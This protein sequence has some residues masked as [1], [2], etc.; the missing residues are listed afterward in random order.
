[1]QTL[2]FKEGF[3]AISSASVESFFLHG[4][5]PTSPLR[6]GVGI[7]TRISFGT[8]R[9]R[10]RHKSSLQPR[11]RHRVRPQSG[12]RV[13][14]QRVRC[15]H[16]YHSTQLTA[17]KYLQP[18]SIASCRTS[19]PHSERLNSRRENV[20]NLFP[21]PASEG[22]IRIRLSACSRTCEPGRKRATLSSW[23]LRRKGALPRRRDSRAERRQARP[24][25]FREACDV[26]G[27]RDPSAPRRAF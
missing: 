12:L 14:R 6:F 25:S 5:V 27:P 1:M 17:S 26:R 4:G 10:R 16:R 3:S 13:E 20:A 23:R 22:R 11:E 9:V 24:V 15:D 7:P 18:L 2:P 21:G 19:R 8:G